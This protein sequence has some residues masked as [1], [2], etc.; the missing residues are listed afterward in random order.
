MRILCFH[1]A[2]APYR[3]DFFNLLAEKVDLKI[4]F[5]RHNLITQKFDQ[6]ALRGELK[7]W[8]GELTRGFDIRQRTFRFGVLR[9]IRKESPEVVFSYEASPV[10]LELCILKKLHLIR[11]SIWTSMDDSPDQVKSRCGFRRV[12]RDWVIRNVDKVI[13][14][15]EAAKEAYEKIVEVQ[16]RGRTLDEGFGRIEHVETCRIGAKYAVV[17]IIHDTE[18]LRKNAD[19]IFV[20]GSAWREE[21]C[22]NTWKRVLVFVGRLAEI[23]NIPWIIDR[24]SE[25]PETTGLVVVG[26][27]PMESAL[28]S[29]VAEMGLEGRVMFAGRK[30]G[31]ELYSIMAASDSLVLASKS[32]PFGA[33]V[34]E[35]LAWGTPCLVADNC[36]AAV[37]IEDGK[38]G[39]VFRYGD[40]EDF[41]SALARMPERSGESLLSVELRD[42]VAGLVE[43]RR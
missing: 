31:D 26:E 22:P 20:D 27:G 5:L 38:N 34:A 15:S 12:L 16:S 9:A 2:L 25:L 19:K 30:N 28:K 39:A 17:P 33:V 7:C 1:P 4:L 10:T 6:E 42:A 18:T 40:R 37:L 21:H 13:V 14:P 36:G 11:S 24:L 23:K 43:A 41:K 8:H 35:A 29:K 32:E 3:V